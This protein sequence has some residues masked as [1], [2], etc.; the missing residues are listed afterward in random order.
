MGAVEA[1]LRKKPVIV[2]DFGGLK[3]YVS[4]P[5]LVKCSE[6]KIGIDDFLFSADMT[7]GEPDID[8]LVM[9]MK[10]CFDK[11]LEFQD[12]PETIEMMTRAAQSFP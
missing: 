12:H 8:Q 9:F 7:W 6:T 3:E 10:E 5:F 11:R 1:A 4:T 2:T